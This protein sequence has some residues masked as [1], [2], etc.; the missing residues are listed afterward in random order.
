[1]NL[2]LIHD[3]L[4]EMKMPSTT[5]AEARKFAKQN[6]NTAKQCREHMK[7]LGL[8][9]NSDQ[10]KMLEADAKDFEARAADWRKYGNS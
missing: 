10:Y 7:S 2:S 4:K 9:T 8:D 5:K 1:M 3:E 6:A